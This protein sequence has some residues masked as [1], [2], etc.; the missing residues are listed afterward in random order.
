MKR[1][2]PNNTD[3]EINIG[4]TREIVAEKARTDATVVGAASARTGGEETS[5]RGGEN[6]LGAANWP[7]Y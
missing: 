2:C 4:E 7:Q 6:C 1:N 5:I 3:I